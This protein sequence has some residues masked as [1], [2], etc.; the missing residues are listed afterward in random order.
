MTSR[1]L[2][3]DAAWY[4]WLAVLTCGLVTPA[5]RAQEEVPIELQDIPVPES[6]DGSRAHEGVYL[7]DSFEAEGLLQEASEHAAA[8]DWNTALDKL[9]HVLKQYERRVIGS[10]DATYISVRRFLNAE[11]ARWPAKGLSAY[12]KRYEPIAKSLLTQSVEDHDEEKLWEVLGHYFCTTSAVRAADLLSQ[13]LLEQGRLGEARS[14]FERLLADH[15]DRQQFI[16]EWQAKQ[17]VYQALSG[18]I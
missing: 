1:P 2:Y 3:S 17:A 14:I 13:M 9:D 5:V 6:Q 12:R 10:G 7:N 16:R 8:A 15:P 18:R 4:L 11:I